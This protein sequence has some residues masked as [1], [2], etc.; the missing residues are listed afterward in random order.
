MVDA[1]PPGNRLLPVTAPTVFLCIGHFLE[2][3]QNVPIFGT[4]YFLPS[5]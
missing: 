1:L 4:F 3:Q 5:R 2:T